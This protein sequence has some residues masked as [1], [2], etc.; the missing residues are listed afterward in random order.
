MPHYKNKY[1]IK[2]RTAKLRLITG[3]EGVFGT[4]AGKVWALIITTPFVKLKF[5]AIIL[6]NSLGKIKEAALIWV[7]NY[8]SPL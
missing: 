7:Q 8:G 5:L 4:L 3:Y 1:T 6:D 2:S